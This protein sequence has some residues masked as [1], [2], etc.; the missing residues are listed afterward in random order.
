MP[1]KRDFKRHPVNRNGLVDNS[2]VKPES[3]KTSNSKY[4]NYFCKVLW[5][6]FE[7]WVVFLGFI[8]VLK[9]I[10]DQTTLYV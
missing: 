8:K 1:Q 2:A 9:P 4:H 10:L 5:L 6:G 3:T 7:A